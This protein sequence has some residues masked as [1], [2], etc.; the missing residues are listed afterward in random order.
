MKLSIIILQHNTPNHVSQNLKHLSLA[1]LPKETQVIIVNNG[2]KQANQ[3]VK[4]PT[5]LS[6]DFFDTPNHGFPTG[7]NYGHSKSWQ[8]SDYYLFLNPDIEVEKNT[9]A[10][11]IDYMN[12]HKTIGITSP[13]LVYPDGS[14][15]DNYRTFPNPI[16]LAIKR[17]PFLRKIF[18]KRMSKYLMWNRDPS[19]TQEVD[20]IT[21]AFTLISKDCMKA[22]KKH[23]D[24]YFLFM[25]DV[26]LCISA[27]S[28]G[29]KTYIIGKVKA[30]HNDSRISN[31][32]IKDVFTKKTVR[33][34]ILDSF[35]YFLKHPFK[36]N[37]TRK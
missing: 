20:W 15:Q 12:K 31:G 6:V 8:D 16:D 7:N 17:I 10:T 26:E 18:S 28:K 24:N 23:N 29:F 37:F 27:K 3:K 11:L 25:S 34:H 21:G 22:I 33:I 32:G 2:G 1:N 4:T 13:K 19:N 5:N 35:K 36:P 14:V 9:I 30:L